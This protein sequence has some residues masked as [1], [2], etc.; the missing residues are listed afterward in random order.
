[1]HGWNDGWLGFIWLVLIL[2]VIVVVLYAVVRIV[3]APARREMPHEDPQP[4]PLE[5]LAERF[6]RGEISSEDYAE[7]R[8]VLEELPPSRR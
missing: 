2:A 7:R 4:G 3:S 1:M 5:I 8:R 6:A